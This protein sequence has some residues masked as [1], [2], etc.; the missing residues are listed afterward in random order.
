[1]NHQNLPPAWKDVVFG[2]REMSDKEV[3]TMGRLTGDHKSGTEFLT[4][5]AEPF[6]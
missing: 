5:T 3:E 2:Y 1:M 4:F 6:R